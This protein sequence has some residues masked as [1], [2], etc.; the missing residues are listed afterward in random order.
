MYDPLCGRTVP[1]GKARSYVEGQW[2][3]WTNSPDVEF[4]TDII[5][6]AYMLAAY[7]TL[8]SDANNVCANVVFIDSDNNPMKMSD[9]ADAAC[10]APIEM[11]D[12]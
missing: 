9:I 3:E 5:G 11:L 8:L 1:D 2:E 12:K 6:T 7:M 10:T 4:R